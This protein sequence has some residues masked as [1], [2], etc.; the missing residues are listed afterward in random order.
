MPIV[1]AIV[2]PAVDLVTAIVELRMLVPKYIGYLLLL[3]VL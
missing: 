3:D 2:I 1:I